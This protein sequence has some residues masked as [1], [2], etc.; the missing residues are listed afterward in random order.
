MARWRTPT[1][2]RQRTSP[3]QPEQRHMTMTKGRPDSGRPFSTDEPSTPEPAAGDAPRRRRPFAPR[4]HG[5]PH[6]TNGAATNGSA[7]TDIPRLAEGVELI[8]EFEGSGYKDPPRIARGP[9]GQ[10]VQM[11]ALLYAV[12]EQID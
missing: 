4:A 11:P 2:S 3:S 7:A 9:S 12:A 10:P 1:P 8:G 5:R 6:D